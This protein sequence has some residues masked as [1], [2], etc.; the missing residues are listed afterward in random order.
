MDPGGAATPFVILAVGL[1]SG[2]SVAPAATPIQAGHHAS[3]GDP[4]SK[5]KFATNGWL[6]LGLVGLLVV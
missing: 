5:F 6:L 3:E 1:A 4:E 2:M